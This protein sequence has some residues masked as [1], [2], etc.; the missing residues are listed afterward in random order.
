[1]KGT[2]QISLKIGENIFQCELV[3]EDHTANEI[4][5]AFAAL[6]VGHTF[7][8]STVYSAMKVVGEDNLNLDD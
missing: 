1:M 2:T 4:L 3:G 8:P 7:L 6:M 5:E